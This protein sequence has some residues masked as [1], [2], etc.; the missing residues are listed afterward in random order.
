MTVH[1]IAMTT[2]LHERFMR[3]PDLEAHYA[4]AQQQIA[5]LRRENARLQEE[6]D[7]LKRL[8]EDYQAW[9]RLQVARLRRA[10]KR[11]KGWLYEGA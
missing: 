2:E 7:V 6:R 10:E 3:L 4:D 5:A 8:V 9:E 11:M 1:H